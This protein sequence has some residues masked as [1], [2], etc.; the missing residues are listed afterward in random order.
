MHRSVWQWC[1]LVVAIQANTDWHNSTS[2]RAAAQASATTWQ[3]YRQAF[4]SSANSSCT[5]EPLSSNI[6]LSKACYPYLDPMVSCHSPYAVSGRAHRFDATLRAL[7]PS[8]RAHLVSA[9]S[10]FSIISVLIHC[11]QS[12]LSFT[13]L[14]HCSHC[15]EYAQSRSRR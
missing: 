1:L 8:F 7:S 3:Y 10:L 13:A 4:Y 14:I 15:R 9:Q 6:Y 5:G 11:S 12:L 2:K